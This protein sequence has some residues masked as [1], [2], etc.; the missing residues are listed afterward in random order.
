MADINRARMLLARGDQE[1]ATQELVDFLHSHGR[2]V[3]GWLMLADLVE[4]PVERKDCYNQVLKFDPDNQQA[5]LQM[6][7]LGDN[8]GLKF[9][10]PEPRKAE[11]APEPPPELPAP[12]P[13][14]QS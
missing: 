10:K 7:L 8:P 5:R 12:A 14:L 1:A 13:C 4:D 3:E 9:G 11:K 2:N 6:L